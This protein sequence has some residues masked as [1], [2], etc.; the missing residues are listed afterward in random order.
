MP[1]RNIN[2]IISDKNLSRSESKHTTRDD[3]N[4]M[5]ESGRISLVNQDGITT[6]PND[7]RKSFFIASEELLS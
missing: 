3:L 6:K 2:P 5:K 7:K 4:N 1:L